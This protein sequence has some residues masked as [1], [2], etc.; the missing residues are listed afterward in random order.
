VRLACPGVADALAVSPHP[1]RWSTLISGV[2][3][4]AI[5]SLAVLVGTATPAAAA[6][7][8][9]VELAAGSWLGGAGVVVHSNGS[10]QG[11]GSSC[12]GL[13]IANPSA[14]Y[15]YGWQCVELAARLYAVKGWG[16]V[17][18]DG[19]ASAGIYRYGAKYIP[20]GS[21]GLAFHPNGKGYLPVPGDLII[22]S[23]SSGW[24]HVSIVDQSVGNSVYAVEQNA[25]PTGR[26]TYTLTG[27]TLTG[28]YGGTVRG[29]MHAPA[30]TATRG[31]GPTLTDGRFIRVAGHAEIYR[32]AGGAPI[33]VSTWAAFGGVQPTLVISAANLNSLRPVP[34]DGTFVFGA[35]RREVYRIAG[36]APIYVSTWAAFG[37][38]K[39]TLSLD[40]VAIDKAG[41]GGAWNHLN[42][43]P[44]DGTFVAGAQSGQAYRFAG[45]APLYVSTWTPFGGPQP[46]VVVDQGALD[47]AGAASG[48]FSHVLLAPA[49]GTF[50]TGVPSGRVFRVASGVATVVSSWTPYGGP[51]PTVAVSDADLNYAGGAIPWQHLVSATAV[52]TLN[53]LSTPTT[54]SQVTLS[55]TQPI[56]ASALSSFDVRWQSATPATAFTSWQYPA[57]WSALTATSVGSGA[58][59][60]GTTYCYSVRAHNLARGTGPWS[61]AQCVT[62]PADDRAFTASAGWTRP[63]P[64]GRFYASTYSDSTRTG[65]TLT[66]SGTQVSRLSL[67]ATRCPTCGT[68]GVY[69]GTTL[70][71]TINLAATTTQR[72]VLFAIAPFSYRTGT[73]TVKVTSSGR[74]VQVD[75]VAISPV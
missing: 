56:T 54:A 57:G 24:G 7:C 9:A 53:P 69:V 21:P 74:L 34:A 17:Y 38:S 10:D 46:F 49:D 16:R 27:S 30:N 22:E 1:R 6:A 33:Y 26:H 63:A 48:A 40:Q 39:P 31:A 14:Q 45:G 41:A 18:A 55:W 5:V 8:S 25:S 62:R 70:V 36:G 75:G 68:V 44:K 4:V 3:T 71:G 65:A 67:L 29:F 11:T 73:V 52:S 66:L 42:Y 59:A 32:I 20:E 28:Q 37:G 61:P 2:L 43:R 60:V 35:Q 15:G 13:S 58:L 47:G 50:L 12:A 23:Y 19:G 64:D 51:K 72:Q